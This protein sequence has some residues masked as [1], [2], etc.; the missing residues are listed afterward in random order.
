MHVPQYEL[1]SMQACSYFSRT[2]SHL[3]EMKMWLV[4]L[5]R[6]AWAKPALVSIRVLFV[7]FTLT[8]WAL[9]P[10]AVLHAVIAASASTAGH[11]CGQQLPAVMTPVAG[12]WLTLP[13]PEQRQS[14]CALVQ[15]S[16]PRLPGSTATA[17]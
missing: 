14:P 13:L 6:S 11:A 4:W 17:A 3:H 15:V 9:A 16:C 12:V 7:M 8:I 1:R 2:L 10:P 5:A